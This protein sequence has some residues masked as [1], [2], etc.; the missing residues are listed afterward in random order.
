MFTFF[1]T[2]ERRTHLDITSGFPIAINGNRVNV[3]REVLRLDNGDAIVTGLFS[4]TVSFDASGDPSATLTSVGKTDIFIARYTRAGALLWVR[5]FGGSAGDVK[6]NKDADKPLDVAIRPSRLDTSFFDGVGADVKSAGEYANGLGIAPDGSIYV[7]GG[8]RARASFGGTTSTDIL[9][10]V[11][12]Y[13]D[14]FLLKLTEDGDL[15]RA[16]QFGGQFSDLALDMAVD[17]QGNVLLG[18]VF[19]RTADFDPG[20]GK[21]NLTARGRADAFT[22]KYDADGGLVW[23]APMGSDVT[24]ANK[25]EAVNGIAVDSIG[26]AYITGT[27]AGRADFNPTPGKTNVLWISSDDETDI[28]TAVLSTRGKLA[29]VKTQGG[30]HFDGARAIALVGDPAAPNVITAA[31]FDRTIDADPGPADLKL[32]AAPSKPGDTPYASDLL[33]TRLE[34]NGD[35]V[36]AKQV[37]GGYFETIGRLAVDRNDNIYLTGGFERT[38]DFDPGPAQ[39]NLTSIPTTREWEDANEDSGERPSSYD[40]YF[41]SLDT[42]GALR[43]A[44]QFGG[45][46]DE[47][48]FG[49]S[50]SPVGSQ[51]TEFYMTGRFGGTTNL[52]PPPGSI[53]FTATGKSSIFISLFDTE[54]ALG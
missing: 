29:W 4:E 3:G 14:V 53:P 8:F 24:K 17:S 50:R 22:A 26:N 43:F 44:E 48:S 32:T 41:M 11:E 42:N 34:N 21:Y 20:P 40:G 54:G 19:T 5:R 9:S 33:I 31:Y 16:Q 18:G 7:T 45:N 36:W 27:F 13:P 28:F 35:F 47:F 2:L 10:T 51:V 30:P 25:V 46:Q 37:G 1:E 23:V 39:F 49:L 38:V 52:S 6:A 15:L 12:D